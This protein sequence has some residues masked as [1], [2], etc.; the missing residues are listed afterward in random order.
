MLACAAVEPPHGAC[1]RASLPAPLKALM[2]EFLNFVEGVP[3]TPALEA[4]GGFKINC[5][6][7]LKAELA[8]I[9]G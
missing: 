4:Y 7:K 8:V 6:P 3:L 9:Q 5:V 1:M 2:A